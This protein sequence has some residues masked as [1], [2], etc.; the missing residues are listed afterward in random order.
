MI[1]PSPGLREA[2]Y[3]QKMQK[4]CHSALWGSRG[5]VS[6]PK[7]NLSVSDAENDFCIKMHPLGGPC[8]KGKLI[9]WFIDGFGGSRRPRRQLGMKSALLVAQGDLDP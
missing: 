6:A 9:L 8:Q 1:L 7:L 5:I 3:S 4:M 2:L